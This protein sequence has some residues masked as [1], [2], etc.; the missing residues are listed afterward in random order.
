MLIFIQTI[1][2][3]RDSPMNNCDV[4][5]KSL[6]ATLRTIEHDQHLDHAD[7]AVAEVKR[8]LLLKI[9]ALASSNDHPRVGS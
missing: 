5:T 8:I 7:P 4:L 2:L 6:E 1:Y 9:A 3:V